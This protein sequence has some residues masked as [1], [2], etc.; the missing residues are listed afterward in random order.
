MPGIDQ[1]IHMKKHH[2]LRRHPLKTKGLLQF[3]LLFLPPDCIPLVY[4]LLLL[5]HDLLSGHSSL[6]GALCKYES[7]SGHS[8]SSLWFRHYCRGLMSLIHAFQGGSL[9]S[10]IKRRLMV[11]HVEHLRPFHCRSAWTSPVYPLTPQPLSDPRGGGAS[12]KRI[13]QCRAFSCAKP[14]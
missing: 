3:L 13:S 6:Q 11:D 5:I 8:S 1:C 12:S 9:S 7:S 14:Q 4:P 2:E 10:V